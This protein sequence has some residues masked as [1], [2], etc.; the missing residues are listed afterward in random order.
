MRGRAVLPGRDRLA[1]LD[2][3]DAIRDTYGYAEQ[4]AGRGY[5]GVT[6]LNALLATLSTP[7]Q[8]R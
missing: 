7:Q 2:I 4:G 8:P 5:S 6:G 3:D 1:Y